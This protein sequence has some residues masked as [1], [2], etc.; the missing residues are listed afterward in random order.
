VTY[1]GTPF[2]NSRIS[3]MRHYTLRASKASFL[4]LTA[5]FAATQP[6]TMAE[7]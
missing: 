6:T 5:V 4:L 7:G 3:G 2:N 1:G